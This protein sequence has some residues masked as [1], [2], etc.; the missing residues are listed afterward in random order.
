MTQTIL[1]HVK[2][3]YILNS[4]SFLLFS[5]NI[6]NIIASEFSS[7]EKPRENV[8][9]NTIFTINAVVDE[10]SIETSEEKSI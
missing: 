8:R 5:S 10:D 4:A 6:F 7:T 3:F 9:T 2:Y 1:S